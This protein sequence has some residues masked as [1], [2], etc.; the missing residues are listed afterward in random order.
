MTKKFQ[1][2]EHGFTAEHSPSWPDRSH[3]PSCR[4]KKKRSPAPDRRKGEPPRNEERRRRMQRRLPR[5]L[6]VRLKSR[7]AGNNPKKGNRPK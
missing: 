1:Q 2:G 7:P 6:P 3:R 4:T 5:R